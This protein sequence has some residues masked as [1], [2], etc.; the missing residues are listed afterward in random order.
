MKRIARFVTLLVAVLGVLV[1]LIPSP[2]L[3]DD[4]RPSASEVYVN[5]VSLDNHTV[6]GVSYDPNYGELT[7]NNYKGGPIYI[8]ATSARDL[9]IILKGT[10]IITCTGVGQQ[11]YGIFI[12]PSGSSLD[13]TSSNVG[14][15]QINATADKSNTTV[16][17]VWC[18]GNIYFTGNADVTINVSGGTNN[19]YTGVHS[20]NGSIYIEDSSEVA[21]YVSGSSAKRAIGLSMGSGCPLYISSTQNQIFDLHGVSGCTTF[22][23]NTQGSMS[24]PFVFSNSPVV[25][26]FCDAPRDA[27]YNSPDFPTAAG[28]KLNKSSYNTQPHTYTNQ[29]TAITEANVTTFSPTYIEYYGG[30][31]V[32]TIVVK[33]GS[34]TLVR[35]TDYTVS[36]SP[37]DNINVGVI[38]CTITGIGEYRGTVTKTYEVA[39]R[40]MGDENIEVEEIPPQQ[41]NANG[42]AEP[43]VEV[44]FHAQSDMT[45]VEGRDYI[46]RYERNDRLNLNAECYVVGQGNYGGVRLVR[47]SIIPGTTKHSITVT[48]GMAK[49][50]GAS[51]IT[52]ATSGTVVNLSADPAPAGKKFGYWLITPNTIIPDESGCFVMPDANVTAKAVYI[53]DTP[54]P[55]GGSMY[56]LY[57]QWTY[58]H[59]YTESETER[60]NLKKVGWT[61][62]G[63][64]WYAP[65]TGDPVYRLYNPWAPGGDHHYTTSWNEY[66]TCINAGWRGEGI[67]WYSS[68][69]QYVPIYREYNPYESAHNHNYTADLSEHNH[70]VSLGWQDE[71]VGWY[72]SY[73]G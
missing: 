52:Q 29:Q 25:T 45:L 50:E 38:T 49:D 54:A 3:A 43:S 13:I 71:G 11:H 5:G 14:T 26:F 24:T 16:N 46:L 23:V 47:F 6:S 63:V 37:T 17:A 27:G 21:V 33:V 69:G 68:T 36:F 7:L 72:G 10:N 58:E 70:L 18:G 53:A 48:G 66:M 73:I 42:V 39:P 35:D 41:L 56:R 64:G 30:H 51:T 44:I 57:N 55:T 62:E 40:D 20:T 31:C 4:P 15:L 12:G 8:N 61:Y 1:A 60:D 28:Y 32:P 65:A 2:A 19:G 22:G 9:A 34:K 59:F 67:G